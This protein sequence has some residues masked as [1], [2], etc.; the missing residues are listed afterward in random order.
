MKYCY[1][2]EVEKQT[3]VLLK[4]DRN[5]LKFILLSIVTLGVY[6]VI[7]YIS[8]S[9]DI[10]KIAR[11]H[12]GKKTFNYLFACIFALFTFSIVLAIWNY[13]VAERIGDELKRRNI[14]FEFGSGT[15]LGWGYFGSLII[16]GPYIYAFKICK[17]M[18][19]LCEDYNKNN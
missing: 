8:L 3:K 15:Y 10:D 16:V 2:E 12:D 11:R 17:A 14:D 13:H 6:S 1:D 5:A 4:T 7:F 9:F 18:N 19:L